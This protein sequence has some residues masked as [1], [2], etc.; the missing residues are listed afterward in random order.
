MLRVKQGDIYL[1]RGDT[2][3]LEVAI[4]YENGRLYEASA[5]DTITLSIKKSLSNTEYALQKEVSGVAAII[6]MPEDTKALECGKYLYDVQLLTSN[7]E[8]FTVIPPSPFY[9]EGE[10]TE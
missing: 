7:G 9:L 6:I 8:V 1:T 4:A 5:G 3:Y 10:V 2:A